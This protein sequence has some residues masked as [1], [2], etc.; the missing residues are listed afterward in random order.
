[1]RRIFIYSAPCLFFVTSLVLSIAL[2]FTSC[3][4][5]PRQMPQ[6]VSDEV[7]NSAP[8]SIAP[9]PLVRPMVTFIELGSVNCV[10]CRAMQPIMEEVRNRYGSQ[11]KV[12]FYDVWTKEGQPYGQKYGIRVIPTQVF[13]DRE[14][15]EYFRHEGFF[16]AEEL[17]NILE[18]GGVRL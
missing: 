11:V 14:G 17:L 9:I 3:S 1:M 6:P 5:P 18:Q 10:P 15:K 7:N 4:K 2:L 12:L 8:H 16:P 13:L